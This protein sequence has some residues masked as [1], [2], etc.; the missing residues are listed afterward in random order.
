MK[1]ITNYLSVK[2]LIY[3]LGS[4]GLLDPCEKDKTDAVSDLSNQERE[5]LTAGAQV[6]F[7]LCLF[8]LK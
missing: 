8:F 7:I 3:L 6:S 2:L 1:R 4:C 5:D